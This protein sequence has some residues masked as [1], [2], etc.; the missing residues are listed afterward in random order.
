MKK[1]ILSALALLLLV[2][3][4][5]GTLAACKDKPQDDPEQTTDNQES[6][7]QVPILYQPSAFS[8]S[9]N[10]LGLYMPPKNHKALASRQA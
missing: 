1:K 8:A 5:A 7:R 10:I 3:M 6:T 2:S 4:L 9:Q